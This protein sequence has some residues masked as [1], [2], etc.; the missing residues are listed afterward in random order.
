M[1]AVVWACGLGAWTMPAAAQGFLYQLEILDKDAITKLT[2]EQLVER[3]ID[4]A[5]ELEAS[6][7]FHHVAGFGPKEY[8]KYKEL[9]RYRVNL[10]MEFRKRNL[11]VPSIEP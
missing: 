7:E 10:L 11:A 1:L 4:M 2:D 3:Y 6:R 9:L 5:I 8:P